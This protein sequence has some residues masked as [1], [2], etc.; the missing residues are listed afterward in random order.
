MLF[1]SLT[2]PYFTT[3]GQPLGAMHDTPAGPKTSRLCIHAA[4]G[5]I[6][7]G[8]TFLLFF[9]LSSRLTLLLHQSLPFWSL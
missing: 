8:N 6:Y 2:Q 5:F 7:G 9:F 3:E 1:C 4:I